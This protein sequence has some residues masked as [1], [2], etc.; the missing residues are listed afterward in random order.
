MNYCCLSDLLSSKLS[1]SFKVDGLQHVIPPWYS[2]KV[3]QERQDLMH[4]QR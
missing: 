1:S 2:Q 4:V 3:E